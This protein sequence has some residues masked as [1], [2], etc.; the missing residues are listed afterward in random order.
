[1]PKPRKGMDTELTLDPADDGTIV[2]YLDGAEVG[3]RPEAR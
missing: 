3:W 2:L 1:M